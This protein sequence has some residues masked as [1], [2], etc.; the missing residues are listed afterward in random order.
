MTIIPEVIDLVEAL[1]DIA[2]SFKTQYSKAEL[3]KTNQQLRATPPQSN[4][5][6]RPERPRKAR[7]PSS[8]KERG[9]P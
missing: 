4:R 7:S 2:A 8:P 5:Q 3:C 6:A 9:R 1:T